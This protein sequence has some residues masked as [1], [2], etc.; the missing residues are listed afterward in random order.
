MYL[1]IGGMRGG[2]RN[3]VSG[4][5]FTKVQT[6][7]RG[8]KL[9]CVN[10]V[11]WLPMAT[12]TSSFFLMWIVR[13]HGVSSVCWRCGSKWIVFFRR[14]A[15]ICVVPSCKFSLSD[16][17]LAAAFPVLLLLPPPPHPMCVCVVYSHGHPS[18]PSLSCILNPCQNLLP[19]P[20]RGELMK[21]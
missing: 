17:D 2:G 12:G 1:L 6:L 8:W 18:T 15:N 5:A 7:Y 3:G 16:E 20:R 10:L 11:S 14:A 19:L 21:Q 9:G 13:P 4:S